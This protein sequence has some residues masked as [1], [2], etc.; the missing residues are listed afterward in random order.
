MLRRVPKLEPLSHP[1]G[2]LR[3][4]GFLPRCG[5]VRVP[6]V[7][8]PYDLLA[9]DRILRAFPEELRP[10]PRRASVSDVHRTPG[11][12][13]RERQEEMGRTVSLVFVVDDFWRPGPHGAGKAGFLRRLPA[14]LIPADPNL[15]FGNLPRI[16]VPHL[17]P[18]RH[19][20]RVAARGKAPVRFQ[21]RLDLLFFR[22]LRTVSFEML[23]T[24]SLSIRRP[25]RSFRVPRT[26]PS[27]G[28]E[29]ARATRFA[30]FA[31]SRSF[32][33]R[34]SG[35]RRRR[36]ASRPSRT[37]RLRRR[38]T[39][40]APM[41]RARARSTSRRLPPAR[42][43]SAIRSICARRRRQAAPVPSTIAWSSRRSGTERRTRSSF[44]P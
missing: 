23:S 40:E 22:I 44:L 14:G 36:A 16:R 18:R 3:C 25:A 7:H 30:S 8:D 2:L 39:V 20:R 12:V 28:E 1:Q 32:G 13:G 6:V 10:V 34:F 26:P 9:G 42:P 24:I 11:F 35:S 38:S 15:V 4:T 37:Q 17:L 29:P 43:S 19:E 31:P 5:A 21:P 33:R 27:G 41:P